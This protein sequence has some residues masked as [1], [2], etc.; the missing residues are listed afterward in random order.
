MSTHPGDLPSDLV[1]DSVTGIAVRLAIAGPG[2]RSYAFI[3]D[4]HIRFILGFCWYLFA[5][6]LYNGRLGL[7]APPDH[8]GSWFG[9]V[10][11]PAVA[12]YLLYHPVLELAMR[13]RTPG[14]R[15]AGVYLVARDGGVPSA[16]ALLIRN[17]FR[18]IDSLPA[19]YAVGLLAVIL[20]REHLRV[21]DMAAGT[22]PRVRPRAPALD[23]GRGA[24]RQADAVGHP[25]E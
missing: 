6:L 1:V 13:G 19:F 3:I 25:G 14:K 21:G 15:M 4:W 8:A 7:V 24:V 2:A 16:G 20:T 17:V 22:G 23:V 10:L 5:A 12:I 9:L 18:L 11:L